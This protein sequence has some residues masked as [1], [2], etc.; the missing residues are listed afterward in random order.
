MIDLPITLAYS[1]GPFEIAALIVIGLLIFGKRLP[2][3]GR[4]VGRSITEFK[5]GIQGIES[6]I[7][8]A[9]A[10]SDAKKSSK[11]LDD[12]GDEPS[13]STQAREKTPPDDRESR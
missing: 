7:D 1:I 10:E 9:A 8:E 11:S 5:K 13:V 2:E 6:D 3:V 4:S 12:K